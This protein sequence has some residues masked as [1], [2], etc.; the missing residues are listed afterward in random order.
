G[1]PAAHELALGR[2]VRIAVIDSDID[3]AHPDLK[4]AVLRSFDA[5]G[6]RDEAADFH[7]TA[8]AGIIRA[9]GLVEGAAPAAEILAVRAFRQTRSSPV[10]E[11]ATD[12]LLAAVDW[13]VGH[14]A[15]ILNMSFVGSHDPALQQIIHAANEKGII[16]VAAAGN[17]G[18]N[19]PAA[20]PAA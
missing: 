6:R 19:G 16:V 8:V 7:G 13:S 10:P 3:A 2:N 12:I 14:G 9:N 4:G 20:Y 1:L 11:T 17:A 18:R 15:K 5:V